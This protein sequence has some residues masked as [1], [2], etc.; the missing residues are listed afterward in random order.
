MDAMTLIM[1]ATTMGGGRRNDM[2]LPLLLMSMSGTGG[3]TFSNILTPQNI[4]IGMLPAVGSLGKMMIGGA[5]A[6]LAGQLIKG[7][8]R[9]RR[10]RP[11]TVVVNRGGGYRRPYRR[12]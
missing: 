12:Y 3:S 1:L 7:P 10:N 2:L 9:R 11:R 6:V 4:M 8:A 5:G